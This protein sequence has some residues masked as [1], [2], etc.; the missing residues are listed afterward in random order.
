MISARG[1]TPSTVRAPHNR[2]GDFQ[3]L[4][5]RGRCSSEWTMMEEREHDTTKKPPLL[6]RNVL[7]RHG[8]QR[9]LAWLNE[10]KAR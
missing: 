6:D 7:S 10:L 8:G 1:S 9:N 4:P 3:L 5:G 2:P